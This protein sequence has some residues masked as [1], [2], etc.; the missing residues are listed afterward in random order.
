MNALQLLKI[1]YDNVK[2]IIFWYNVQNVAL[3]DGLKS[4]KDAIR[5]YKYAH[6]KSKQQLP[7][8]ADTWPASERIKALGYDPMN[9]NPED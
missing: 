3:S 2:P 5:L 9:T 1:N 8:L 7:E 6:R 4:P